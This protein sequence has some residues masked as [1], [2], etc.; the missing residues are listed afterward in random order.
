MASRLKHLEGMV[1]GMMDADGNLIPQEKL[2]SSDAPGPANED[3]PVATGQVIRSQNEST[4]FVG[5]THCMAML[6]DVSC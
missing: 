2:S 4:A 1:R 5:A 6:E 3:S